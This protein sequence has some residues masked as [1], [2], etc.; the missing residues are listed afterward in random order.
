MK[1]NKSDH[2]RFPLAKL[3]IVVVVLLIIMAFYLVSALGWFMATYFMARSGQLGNEA[4]KF[5]ES[6]N[7]ADHIIRSL[8]VLLIVVS[9]FLLLFFRKSV[10]KLMLVSI[11]LSLVSS[12]LIGRWGIS[13]LGGLYGLILLLIVYAYAYVLN[14]RGFLH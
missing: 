12:I 14:R 2:R 5:Y 13:F 11:V 1:N 6:L 9:S 8:Q 4:T 10:L 7:I 3:V